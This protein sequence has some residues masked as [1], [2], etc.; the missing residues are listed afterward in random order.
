MRVAVACGWLIVLSAA[1]LLVDL[2]RGRPP[3]AGLGVGLLVA[4][5][6]VAVRI[7]QGTLI[8]AVIA[9]PLVTVVAV[10][11]AVGVRDG[12]GSVR[13]GALSVATQ[14]ALLAPWLWGAT[15]L[16]GVIVLVR[17]VRRR[18]PGAAAGAA[19]A[20]A[21]TAGSPPPR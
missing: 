17:R 9:P 12:F 20:A 3:G 19:R 18:R 8:T 21:R 11:V 5:V 15:V 16:A 4:S 6:L 7:R 10:A 1:G 14:L 2:A 13:A